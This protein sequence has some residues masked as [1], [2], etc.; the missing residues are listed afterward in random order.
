MRL[1]KYY[2][3]ESLKLNYDIIIVVIHFAVFIQVLSIPIFPTALAAPEISC[4]ETCQ[5]TDED[6]LM[7]AWWEVEEETLQGLGGDDQLHGSPY[8]DLLFG[9]EGNDQLYGK[10]G[11]D[12]LVG[13]FG[14]DEVHGG[15][16]DDYISGDQGA[17]IISGGEGDDDITSV[18]ENNGKPDYS[19]D[20]IRCGPGN[21]TVYINVSEDGDEAAEDCENVT[22]G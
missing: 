1:E 19:K 9:D 22:T 3:K 8:R 12:I 16:G 7:T 13:S 11:N 20:V 17:D 21:D 18:S 4:E 14:D 6:D 15:P 5:G 10:D 2:I